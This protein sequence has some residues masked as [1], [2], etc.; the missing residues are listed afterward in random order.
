MNLNLDEEGQRTD[1]ASIQKSSA[2][3]TP[4]LICGFPHSGTRLLVRLLEAMRVFVPIDAIGA[5]EWHY[6][7]RLNKKMLPEHFDRDAIARFP[8]NSATSVIDPDDIAF[9]LA[10][11]GYKAIGLGGSR[12]RAVW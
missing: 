10:A 7:K 1:A 6:G 4:I 3:S 2:F 11:M 8:G 12:T 9:E 5:A